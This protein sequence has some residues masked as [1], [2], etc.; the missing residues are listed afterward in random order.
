MSVTIVSRPSGGETGGLI[1]LILASVKA[2][3]FSNHGWI[4]FADL[5]DRQFAGRPMTVLSNLS[6]SAILGCRSSR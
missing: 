3:Y 6:A 2:E 4:G 5:P 1:E